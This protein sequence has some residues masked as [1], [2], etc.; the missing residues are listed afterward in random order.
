MGE[1]N[2]PI[3]GEIDYFE[4]MTRY[5]CML[6]IWWFA[7]GSLN[8]QNI[9]YNGSFEEFPEICCIIADGQLCPDSWSAS[10]GSLIIIV[11]VQKELTVSL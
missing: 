10:E 3:K 5:L 9:V 8:G 11:T 1:W 4:G 6:T 7:I 2:K